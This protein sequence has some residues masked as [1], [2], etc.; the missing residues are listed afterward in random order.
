MQFARS[1]TYI[2]LETFIIAVTMVKG[3]EYIFGA[4]HLLYLYKML[5]DFLNEQGNLTRTYGPWSVVIA[6]LGAVF[7]RGPTTRIFPNFILFYGT[8]FC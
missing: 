4:P 1:S 2:K 3:V 6:W 5:G 7:H 8:I